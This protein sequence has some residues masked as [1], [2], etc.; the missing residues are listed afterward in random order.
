[1]HMVGL[2]FDTLGNE[3]NKKMYD[4]FIHNDPSFD[5]WQFKDNIYCR[6]SARQDHGARNQRAK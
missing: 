1:M 2:A 4:D 5:N 6:D 3:V